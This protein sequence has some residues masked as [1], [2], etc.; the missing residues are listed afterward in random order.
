[1]LT[2]LRSWLARRI[3]PPTVEVREKRNDGRGMAGRPSLVSFPRAKG[4][5]KYE[6][7]GEKVD[8]QEILRRGLQGDGYFGWTSDH[9][10]E[11]EQMQGWVAVAVAAM[12]KA[13]AESKATV[14]RQVPPDDDSGGQELDSKPV[15]WRHPLVQLLRK[16][17]P[18][19]GYA[20]LMKRVVIQRALTGSAFLWGVRSKED[21]PN[22]PPCELYVVPTALVY[23]APPS[24]DLP[25][26]GYR[27]SSSALLSMF[28]GM[29]GSV[30]LGTAASWYTIDAR[31]MIRLSNYHPLTEGDGLSPLHANR[32]QIDVAVEMEEMIWSILQNGAFP[33][34]ILSMAP[35]SAASSDM[36]QAEIERVKAWI[37]AEYGGPQRAGKMMP[38]YGMT[39]QQLSLALD[40]V[41]AEMRAQNRDNAFATYGV[42]AVVAGFQDGGSYSANHA[43]KQQFVDNV[44]QPEFTEIADLLS[45]RLA[46]HWGEDLT[47]E[48]EAKPVNDKEMKLR[49]VDSKTSSQLYTVDELRAMHGDGPHP[50]PEIGKLPPGAVVPYVQTTF[51]PPAPA[52]DP[53]DPNAADPNA[54]DPMQAADPASDQYQPGDGADAT[55]GGTLPEFPAQADPNKKGMPTAALDELAGYSNRLKG[56]DWSS[57]LPAPTDPFAGRNG[58]HTNGFH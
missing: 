52:G 36:I 19:Y 12:G 6:R 22:G 45:I 33:S 56:F 18:A 2:H 39:Y 23:P 49:E 17:N 31:H 37:D 5:Q 53:N 21:G 15:P 46:D 11:S 48:I 27:V 44:A 30:G 8:P 35:N 57:I 42:S 20:G 14:M 26:G 55:Q 10:E 32:R 3:A 16:P 40:S 28:A 47:V 9:R 4:V 58:F 1:M 13:A 50:D 24:S 43:A 34:G 25:R 51:A 7:P 41:N 54:V 29:Y 38:V